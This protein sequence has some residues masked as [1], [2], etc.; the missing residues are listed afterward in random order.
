MG[1]KDSNSWGAKPGPQE[2]LKPLQPLEVPMR[3]MTRWRKQNP[4]YNFRKRA[5]GWDS[6]GAVAG[7]VAVTAGLEILGHS[8][9][10]LA[11]VGWVHLGYEFLELFIAA[12][13]RDDKA[14]E[15]QLQAWNSHMSKTF[16]S[17]ETAVPSSD[18]RE[19]AFDAM[20]GDNANH[21]IVPTLTAAAEQ[22]RQELIAEVNARWFGNLDAMASAKE[23]VDRHGPEAAGSKAMWQAEVA[24]ARRNADLYVLMDPARSEQARQRAE[25]LQGWADGSGN[26][27]KPSQAVVDSY[28]A[29]VKKVLELEANPAN[30]ELT[31]E[32]KGML[33][34]LTSE[35]PAT[36]AF[37]PEPRPR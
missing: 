14:R 19:A 18:L 15:A 8:V 31:P 16:W 10:V 36:P 28:N 9:K 13:E 7:K 30:W 21:G 5:H 11:P 35:M 27:V 4:W 32:Q 12:S 26:Y 24:E 20:V 33:N 29:D 6:E 37:G 25:W 17:N 34:N 2:D 23:F 3:D 22:R 1:G